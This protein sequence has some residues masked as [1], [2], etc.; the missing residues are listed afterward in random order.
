V[1]ADRDIALALR[2]QRL[3]LRSAALR[4]ALAEQSIALETPLATADRGIA[5]ARWLYRQRAWL[6]GGLV[7]VLLM[8]PRRAWRALRFG[9]SLWLAARRVQPWLVAAGMLAPT[10]RRY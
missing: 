10:P 4:D 8:R 1:S 9:W 3:L 2:Q 6:A 5:G 7:V